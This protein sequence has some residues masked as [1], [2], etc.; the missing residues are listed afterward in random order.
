MLLSW[1][2]WLLIFVAGFYLLVCTDKHESGWLSSVRYF[3][4]E[5]VPESL[6]KTF[7]RICGERFAN[8]IEYLFEYMIYRPNPI[9]QIIYL[10][11]AVGGFYIYVVYGFCHIPNKYVPGYHKYIGTVV[12]FMC[13]FSYYKACTV[14]PGYFCRATDPKLLKKYMA[15]F[16]VDGI[17]YNKEIKCRTCTVVKP[18]RSKHCSVCD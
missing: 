17:L 1:W 16:K 6:K 7:I 13:Y 18:A 15:A 2:T 14:E 8:A 5:K 10:C 12:M 3:F 11:C 9:V 4:L